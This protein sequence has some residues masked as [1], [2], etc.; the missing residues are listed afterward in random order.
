L[1]AS[2]TV[3]VMIFMTSV[4]ATTSYMA[5]GTLTYDYAYF[6]FFFGLVATAVGQLGV[7]YLVKKYKRMSLI[8]LSIG[9]VIALSTLLMGFQS[10]LSLFG[11]PND[12]SNK[13]CT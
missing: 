13:L 5:F 9:A 4:S 8:S 7:G 3:A 10:V 6:L 2:G 1:V 11:E 12:D